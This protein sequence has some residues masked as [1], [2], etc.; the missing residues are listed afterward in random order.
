MSNHKHI[1]T[2]ARQGSPTHPPAHHTA[3]PIQRP[4]RQKLNTSNTINLQLGRLGCGSKGAHE[5]ADPV[6]GHGGGVCSLFSTCRFTSPMPRLWGGAVAVPSLFP[7]LFVS[8]PHHLPCPECS[9]HVWGRP[10]LVGLG[11]THNGETTSPKS[12]STLWVI[13]GWG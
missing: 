11:A 7:V 4:G 1:P 12:S 8:T 2:M 3:C 9:P 10:V 6:V 5:L 13:Q